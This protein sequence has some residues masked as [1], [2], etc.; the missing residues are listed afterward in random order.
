MMGED[1]ADGVCLYFEQGSQAEP[2]GPF[3]SPPIPSS[4]AGRSSELV[5][6]D[7]D[8]QQLEKQIRRW[9]RRQQLV[10]RIRDE[11][12]MLAH[13]QE[14]AKEQRKS[15]TAAQLNQRIQIED[16]D[17]RRI[18]TLKVQLSRLEAEIDLHQPK[19]TTTA[20]PT[21]GD[22]VR[23]APGFTLTPPNDNDHGGNSASVA[24]ITTTTNN[25]ANSSDSTGTNKNDDTHT[26]KN[27]GSRYNNGD[28]MIVIRQPPRS[29]SRLP[30]M[31]AA[32]ADRP[33]VSCKSRMRR[34]AVN[35]ASALAR[36]MHRRAGDMCRTDESRALRAR[37]R[38]RSWAASAQNCVIVED[39]GVEDR[40]PYRVRWPRGHTYWYCEYEV[41]AISLDEQGQG[42]PS[43]LVLV[44]HALHY[45]AAS[46]AREQ[47][48]QQESLREKVRAVRADVD[49]PRS[50]EDG[51]P[52]LFHE[53]GI[54][55]KSEELHSLQD[56]LAKI[57]VPSS[58]EHA[59][60]PQPLVGVAHAVTGIN[61]QQLRPQPSGGTGESA[62]AAQLHWWALRQK[63]FEH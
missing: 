45:Q 21:V 25:N 26:D 39:E 18:A 48:K 52:P 6:T 12:T 16:S 19:G 54:I 49:E 27:G 43:L 47:E 37:A 32:A 62:E 23:L 63:A 17:R 40:Q 50:K 28:G 57:S 4:A 53:E 61:E 31:T 42:P 11:E 5:D 58:N 24:A 20:R 7:V 22:R 35:V 33:A 46:F 10:Q 14:A 38:F 56:Q 29:A 9:E 30:N 34:N 1:A 55:A 36:G 2:A 8:T 44:V 59:Q 60:D 51:A 41:V 3:E 15:L 13:T